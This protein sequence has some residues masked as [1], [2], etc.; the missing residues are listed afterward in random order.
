MIGRGILLVFLT[1]GAVF[2]FASG[3]HHWR[4]GGG[5]HEGWRGESCDGGREGERNF[6]QHVAQLCA[7]AALR[8]RAAASAPT[9]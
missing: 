3:I 4:H 2:G 6:E 1:L 8:A 9:P 7:D 5:W